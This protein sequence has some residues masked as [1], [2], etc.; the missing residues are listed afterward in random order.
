M[1][2]SPLC[3]FTQEDGGKRYLCGVFVAWEVWSSQPQA[4]ALRFERGSE[5][6]AVEAALEM[7]WRAT[8]QLL[9][10]HKLRADAMYGVAVAHHLQLPRDVLFS[11]WD[12]V[13]PINIGVMP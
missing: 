11:E 1:T 3:M 2:A 13:Q 12:F 4:Y 8:V 5:D 10:T 6:R 9:E 7:G